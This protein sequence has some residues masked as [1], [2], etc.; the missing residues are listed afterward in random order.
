M[1]SILITS[2][3]K[4]GTGKTTIAVNMSVILAYELRDKSQYPVVLVDLGLD[5]GT[6]SMLLLGGIEE[7]VPYSLADYFMGRVP[8][9]LSTL[10]V[11]TWQINGDS[12]KLVFTASLSPIPPGQVKIDRYL[13]RGF[14]EC[15]KRRVASIRIDRYA[16]PW[17]VIRCIGHIT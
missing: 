7:Q 10:Y 14:N 2:G 9:P 15:H 5:S 11:K 6:T 12:F 8:D 16:S 4:G 1:K 13:L 17:P 3:T